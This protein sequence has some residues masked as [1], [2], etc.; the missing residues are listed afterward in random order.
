MEKW[1]IDIEIFP[2]FLLVKVK[3]LGEDIWIEF[4]LH[5]GRND[6]DALM[7]FL[8]KRYTLIGFN[9]LDFDGQIIEYIWRNG[10]TLTIQQIFEFTQSLIDRED[11]F[12]LP[13]NEWDLSFRYIDLYKINHYDNPARRT[14][15]K[16]LE[17]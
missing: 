3:K 16:W 7:E 11:R 8:G 2:N 6:L 4:Y 5:E 12:D 17:Y 10:S 1:V 9:V 15:L 14:S 13:Y